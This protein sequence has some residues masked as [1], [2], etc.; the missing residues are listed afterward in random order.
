MPIVGKSETGIRVNTADRSLAVLDYALRRRFG[1]F[2]MTPGFKSEGFA[3]WQQ[4]V[5]NPTL[6]RL[7][8]V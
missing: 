4:E 3:H 1:F 2:G 7:G 5:G 8:R 6:D